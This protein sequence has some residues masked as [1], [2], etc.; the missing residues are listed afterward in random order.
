M[1]NMAATI[2]AICRYPVKG[3]SAEKLGRVDRIPSPPAGLSDPGGDRHQC[4]GLR[5]SLTR[6]QRSID[7]SSRFIKA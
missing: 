2:T 5:P 1:P 4:G 7:P 6:R 3:L